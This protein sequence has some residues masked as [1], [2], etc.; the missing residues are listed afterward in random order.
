M[1]VYALSRY[2]SNGR[3]F[4]RVNDRTQV[5]LWD[6]QLNQSMVDLACQAVGRNL[7]LQEWYRYFDDEPYQQ[8]CPDLP[9]I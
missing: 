8:T 1:S 5:F 7:T 9:P 4:A 6:R 2:N 3:W